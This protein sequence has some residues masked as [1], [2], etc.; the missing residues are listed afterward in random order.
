MESRI[1]IKFGFLPIKLNNFRKKSL[2]KG[3]KLLDSGHV[4]NVKEFQN[5]IKGE[6]IRQTSV[7]L[8]PYNVTI[9][10]SVFKTFKL[11]SK[12]DVVMTGLC[13]N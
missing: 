7:T 2:S 1:E 6:V 8:P 3:K 12:F 9:H 11:I 10:V 13:F 5:I 4:K